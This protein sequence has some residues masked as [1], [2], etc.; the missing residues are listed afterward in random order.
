M[1]DYFEEANIDKFKLNVQIDN[2]NYPFMTALASMLYYIPEDLEELCYED[3]IK[4]IT[5][6]TKTENG[7]CDKLR[8]DCKV[9]NEEG[10]FKIYNCGS[11][12]P[13]FRNFITSVLNIVEGYDFMIG[14]GT[15]SYIAII[16]KG[17]MPNPQSSIWEDT[18]VYYVD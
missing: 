12:E 6:S 2:P 7:L 8:D 5:T 4:S 10:R 14:F 11:N 17:G 3:I 16:K 18:Q 9:V 1:K 13:S 15:N